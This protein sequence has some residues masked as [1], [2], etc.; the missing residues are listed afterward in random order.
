MSALYHQSKL[1]CFY[2]IHV[3]CVLSCPF[4][5]LTLSAV[6]GMLLCISVGLEMRVY[7]YDVHTCVSVTL[8][9]VLVSCLRMFIIHTNGFPALS[10]SNEARFST[11]K[12]GGQ[13][14]WPS[15]FVELMQQ[16][17]EFNAEQSWHLHI[18][19]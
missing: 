5:L 10:F 18:S 19:A 9:N 6:F 7:P 14:H 17:V 3:S 8:R 4:S 16:H 2:F 11:L 12:I 15:G 13:E 1:G